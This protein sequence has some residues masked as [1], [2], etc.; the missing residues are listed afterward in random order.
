MSNTLLIQSVT[1]ALSSPRMSTYFNARPQKSS[2][3]ITA[4]ELYAWNAEVSGCF[5]TPLHICEV[6]IRNAVSEVLEQIYGTNWPN[7]SG[8]HQSLSYRQ[9]GYSPRTDLQ[10]TANRFRIPQKVIP[11]LK[12]A[13]WTELFKSSY[14]QRLWQR[15]FYSIFPNSD[16]SIGIAANRQLV[17]DYLEK[18]RRLRNRI[19]HHEPVFNRNLTD[20]YQ[21]IFTLVEMRCTN[22]VQWM[23]SHQLVTNV[24]LSKP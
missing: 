5:L 12:F 8:F 6:V 7:S 9:H 17:Y 19:A 3:D 24:L 15:N 23:D 22:T 4:L 14:E 10:N 20:D 16:Q 18:L 1:K 13:F 11:E 2:N 21:T